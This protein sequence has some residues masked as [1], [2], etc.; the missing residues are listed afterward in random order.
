MIGAYTMLKLCRY[1]GEKTAED[2]V[3]AMIAAY[4]ELLKKC[5]ETAY[6]LGTV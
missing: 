3:D 2:Y 1:T 5:E 6:R 4:Q